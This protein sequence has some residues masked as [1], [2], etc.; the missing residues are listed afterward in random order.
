MTPLPA[1]VLDDYYGQLPQEDPNI[2]YTGVSFDLQAFNRFSFA[3]P[4]SWPGVIF[5]I[6]PVF[7]AAGVASALLGLFVFYFRRIAESVRKTFPEMEYF[8]LFVLLFCLFL[9]IF[10]TLKS[11]AV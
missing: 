9:V 3:T 11:I 10:V 8:L 1:T 5:D 4:R 6:G 2:D 7:A